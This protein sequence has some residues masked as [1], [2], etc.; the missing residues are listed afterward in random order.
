MFSFLSV[1]TLDLPEKSGS[2]R[3]AIIFETA[4][5][6]PAKKSY[7]DNRALRFPSVQER[8]GMRIHFIRTNALIKTSL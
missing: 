4:C 8:A 1:S 6:V 3:P 5:I 7:D 2:K